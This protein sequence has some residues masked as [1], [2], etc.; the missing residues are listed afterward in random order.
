MIIYQL[1]RLIK[2]GTKAFRYTEKLAVEALPPYSYY[3]LMQPFEKTKETH[4]N[5]E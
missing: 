2:R 3:L 5:L 4:K 1:E